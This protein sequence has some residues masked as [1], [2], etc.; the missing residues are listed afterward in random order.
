MVLNSE[1]WKTRGGDWIEEQWK[2][3]SHPHRKQIINILRKLQP[4]DRLMEIGCGS[5]V[6]LANIKKKFGNVWLSGFDISE[7][8]IEFAK[9]KLPDVHFAM[10]EVPVRNYGSRVYADIDIFLCDA[11]LMYVPDEEIKGAIKNITDSAQKAIILCE[12][13]DNSRLGVIRED[14]WARNYPLLFKEFGWDCKIKKVIWPESRTW[15]SIGK[16]FVARPLRIG[17]KK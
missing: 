5:G 12:W 4:W 6:N 2:T 9:K 10:T 7:D 13:Y 1:Y 16:L 14:H 3:K 15:E 11:V 8:A 17:G